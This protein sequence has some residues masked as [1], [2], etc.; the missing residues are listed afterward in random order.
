MNILNGLTYLKASAITGIAAIS[1]SD[2]LVA[3][4]HARPTVVRPII[5]QR[6]QKPFVYDAAEDRA[7]W[8]QKFG[9]ELT[10]VEHLE[11]HANLARFAQL[12]TAQ[13]R[14]TKK[15]DLGARPQ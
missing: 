13:A 1:M 9:R 8:G 11:V 10:N 14:R 7:Y 3:R 2:V 6:M 4:S 15:P 5:C 12:L